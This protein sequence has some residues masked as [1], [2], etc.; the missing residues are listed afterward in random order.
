MAWHRIWSAKFRCCRFRT[1][2]CLESFEVVTL[3]VKA[4]ALSRLSGRIGRELRKNRMIGRRCI[5][6]DSLITPPLSRR[7][8]ATWPAGQATHHPA[9]SLSDGSPP[10]A[11]CLATLLGKMSERVGHAAFASFATSLL[12]LAPCAG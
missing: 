11:F 2:S 9:L 3:E 6:I 8:P 10:S 12:V 1:S 5:L 4:K 7:F